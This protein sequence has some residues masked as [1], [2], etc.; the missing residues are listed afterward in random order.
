MARPDPARGQ[1]VRFKYLWRRE[2]HEGLSE[3][4]KH[5]PCA[6]VVS[7]PEQQQ[8]PERV[9][10]CAITHSEPE[11]PTVGVPIPVEAKGDTGLDEKCSWVIVS[12]V[13]KVSW[14]STR[15]IR[16]NAGQWTYGV[17]PEEVMETV[18]KAI[19][20]RIKANEIDVIHRDQIDERVNR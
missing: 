8:S 9:M 2:E 1:V 12:E 18:R 7:I 19:M 14:S 4:E 3:G 15:F 20:E 5:R 11:P 13:N 16:T 17:L 10:V 6:V